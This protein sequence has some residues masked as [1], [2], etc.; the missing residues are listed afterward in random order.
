LRVEDLLANGDGA[1][2][3]FTGVAGRRYGLERRE[4]LNTGSWVR[5][6]TAIPESDGQVSLTDPDPLPGHAYYRLLA[7]IP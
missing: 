7:V 3:N 2:V 4:D 1:T 5:V 6:A